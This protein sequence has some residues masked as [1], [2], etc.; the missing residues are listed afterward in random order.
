MPGLIAL[1]AIPDAAAAVEYGLLPTKRRYP[2]WFD[3]YID[4]KKSQLNGALAHMIRNALLHETSLNWRTA[5]FDFD[6]LLIVTKQ[7]YFQLV[8]CSVETPNLPGVTRAVRLEDM[9][10]AILEGAEFWLAGAEADPAK[11]V[12]LDGMMQSRPN[13]FPPIVTGSFVIA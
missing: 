12:L 6:R 10:E 11:K 7:S 13:G 2:Q 5:G 9:A 3:A 4:Q 8:G 1:F